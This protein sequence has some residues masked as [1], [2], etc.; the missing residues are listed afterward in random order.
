MEGVVPG[1]SFEVIRTD[2]LARFDKKLFGI[3]ELGHAETVAIAEEV[4]RAVV[5]RIG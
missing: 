3:E 1:R 2:A 4:A 5:A